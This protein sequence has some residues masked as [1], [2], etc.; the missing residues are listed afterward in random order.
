[1]R[2]YRQYCAL[3]RTLDLLGDRWTLLIIR[4]LAV[5]PC[6]YTDLRDGLPGIATNLLADRLRELQAAGVIS[7]EYAPA[8]VASTLY[9][10][11]DWGAGLRP[12]LIA[13]GRWG[14]ARLLPDG[15]HGDHFRSH[16]ASLG[17]EAV[18]ADADLSGLAP[19]S[20][21]I[22][23]GG[24]PVLL[25]AGPPGFTT[26]PATVRTQADI[27]LAG[28]PDT[29]VALLNGRLHPDQLDPDQRAALHADDDA[30]RR[31]TALTDRA[32]AAREPSPAG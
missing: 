16:W 20:I 32:R 18:Y 3:A 2:S 6:R 7:A 31:F 10:L 12:I 25:T 11:T 26:T 27:T 13:L 24:D 1:V 23:A 14:A 4:E 19:V 17:A 28:E 30:L 9:A 5:R 15:R 22:D 21:L 29:V 8:P